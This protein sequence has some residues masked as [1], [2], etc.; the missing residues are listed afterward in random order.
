MKKIL[1]VATAILAMT[2]QSFA[3]TPAADNNR[4]QE[5]L[6]AEGL[7][8]CKSAIVYFN[9]E[10]HGNVSNKDACRI[11]NHLSASEF[12]YGYK[13]G[14]NAMVVK[15]QKR[16][17]VIAATCPNPYKDDA[18]STLQSENNIINNGIKLK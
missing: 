7:T 17:R 1:L 18:A 10:L 5:C 13:S 4:A 12:M 14:N 16:Q 15:A 2:T 9:R 8:T 3:N 11:A 6:L